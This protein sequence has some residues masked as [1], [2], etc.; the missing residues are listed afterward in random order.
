MRPY[1]KLKLDRAKRAGVVAQLPQKKTP[2]KQKTQ[3]LSH[4][5]YISNAFNYT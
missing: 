3:L 4:T 2:N 5:S 1:L